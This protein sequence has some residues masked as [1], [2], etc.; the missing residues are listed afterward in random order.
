MEQFYPFIIFDSNRD[1]SIGGADLYISFRT[2]G[3]R[4]SPAINMGA[5]VNSKEHE[6]RP[7]ISQDGKYLFFNSLR[8]AN[9]ERIEK[10]Q[11]G[12]CDVYWVGTKVIE[13]LREKF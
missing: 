13:D 8:K 10:K 4:W 9:K 12:E 6:N 11:A 3:N 2:R 1:D 7:N 5:G